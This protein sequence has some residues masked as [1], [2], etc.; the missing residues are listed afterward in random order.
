MDTNDDELDKLIQETQ[1]IW[2]SLKNSGVEIKDSEIDTK[3]GMNLDD[4]DNIATKLDNSTLN[5]INTDI[6]NNNNNNI[7]N[8]NSVNNTNSNIN[9][10]SNINFSNNNSNMNDNS[11]TLQGLNLATPPNELSTLLMSE[12]PSKLS[13]I[14]FSTPTFKKRNYTNSNNNN[15]NNSKQ[16]TNISLPDTPF[17]FSPSLPIHNIQNDDTNMTFSNLKIESSNITNRQKKRNEIDFGANCWHEINELLVKYG[18]SVLMKQH[19]DKFEEIPSNIIICNRFKE[20][21]NKYNK[22]NN[23]NNNKEIENINLKQELN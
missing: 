5:I 23:N 8:I 14:R 12:E 10:I 15:N 4:L 18:F 20:I 11:R 9:D 3:D 17:L 19:N 1:D 16:D 7:N 2:K 22:Y 13:Q 21:L 6:N